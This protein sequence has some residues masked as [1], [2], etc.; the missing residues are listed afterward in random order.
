ME[1]ATK[2]LLL[3]LFIGGG[4]GLLYA[5]LLYSLGR[6][7]SRWLLGKKLS[8]YL[9]PSFSSLTRKDWFIVGLAL[10]LSILTCIIIMLMVWL[11]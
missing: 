2:V 10:L 7:S 8:D 6:G 4:L 9:Y 5:Y 11:F 3:A 1:N